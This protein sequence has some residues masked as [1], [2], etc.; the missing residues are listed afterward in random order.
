MSVADIDDG[1]AD[2]I[3]ALENELN[4]VVVAHH[5]PHRPAQLKAEELKHLQEAERELG[6]TLVA[7]RPGT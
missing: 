4:A 2:R 5:R 1:Q 3:A 6:V 7:Y